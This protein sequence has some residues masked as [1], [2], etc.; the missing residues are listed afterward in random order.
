MLT[1]TEHPL[2][3]RYLICIISV[4]ALNSPAGK[5]DISVDHLGT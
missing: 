5:C 3:A 4:N 2:C 1:F